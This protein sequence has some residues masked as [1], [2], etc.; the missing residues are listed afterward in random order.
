MNAESTQGEVIITSVVGGGPMARLAD[1]IRDQGRP[2]SVLAAMTPET[3]RRRMSGGTPG[4]VL[5]RAATLRFAASV[6]VRAKANRNGVLIVTTNPFFLPMLAVVTRPW[7]GRPVVA[8]IYDLYPDALEAAGLTS[9][10]SLTSLA[11]RA[12]NRL[13]FKRAN[14]VVFIGTAMAEHAQR[15]YGTPQAW[16]VL[17]TG[18]ETAEF[19]RARVSTRA[20][21]ELERWME[22]GCVFAYVGNLGTMHDWETLAL[23]LPRVLARPEASDLRVVIS[24]TGPGS[25]RLARQID[26]VDHRVRFVPPLND[27]SWGRLMIRCQV[28]L[29]TLRAEA[30]RTSIPSKTYSA[31]AAGNAILAVTPLEADLAQLVEKNRAGLVVGPGN[32]DGLVTAWCDLLR[33]RASLAALRRNAEEA[34]RSSFD[35]PAL[36]ARWLEFL[37]TIAKDAT[38]S[39]ASE[40]RFADI[41][42][43]PHVQTPEN[44]KCTR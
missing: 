20:P 2:A 32:V 14:G 3:W 24:A 16:T 19:D 6:L 15:R 13:L 40:T 44:I 26:G 23:A 29:V 31:M 22:E 17:E 33:N 4:R 39:G 28:S 21:T 37:D 38:I 35:M 7:H 34:A 43:P 8:L 36:A 27:A 42:K 41:A 5:A 30:V 18:A 1:A 10:R 12:A 11:V 25:E 9:A